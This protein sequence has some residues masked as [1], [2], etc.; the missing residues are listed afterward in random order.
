MGLLGLLVRS[1]TKLF[2]NESLSRPF[3]SLEDGKYQFV[4]QAGVFPQKLFKRYMLSC[5]DEH[6]GGGGT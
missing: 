3:Q 2:H 4:D 1:V 5:F 6:V